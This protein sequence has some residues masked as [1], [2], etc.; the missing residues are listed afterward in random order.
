MDQPDV[1]VK[2]E[3]ITF[4]PASKTCEQCGK[5]YSSKY[6][7]TRHRRREHGQQP[8][9]TTKSYECSI[10][11]AKFTSNQT[12]KYHVAIVHEKRQNFM[13]HLCTKSFYYRT[14]YRRHIEVE[15]D[16][17]PMASKCKICD[18]EFK[19]KNAIINHLMEAHGKVHETG[20]ERFECTSCG[21]RGELEISLQNHLKFTHQGMERVSKKKKLECDV[22]GKRYDRNNAL[23]THLKTHNDE[24][25]IKPQVQGQAASQAGAVVEPPPI[26]LEKKE[27]KARPSVS[28]CQI[29]KTTYA[30]FWTL[31]KHMKDR[32]SQRL[33]FECRACDEKF[34]SPGR[35]DDHEMR[36]HGLEKPLE[37]A[38]AGAHQCHIC[39]KVV[40]SFF[41]LQKHLKGKH[42][43]KL[44][45]E[46]LP[47]QQKFNTP[48]RLAFHEMKFHGSEKE[49]EET[50][51]ASEM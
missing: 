41:T 26:K 24:Q 8:P 46:C 28:E 3:V 14:H 19:T 33:E 34:Y 40:S 25:M 39:Q 22:C 35:L 50:T 51:L 6:E 13:C 44:E 12:L 27:F 42:A 32:H 23:L 43:Q 29:C 49:S 15:H 31:S 30:S 4:I 16:D 17:F 21:F 1:K 10:C 48:G 7:V 11:N 18:Q 20:R 37:P 9:L 38:S 2:L 36:A 45:F 5:S 47:C